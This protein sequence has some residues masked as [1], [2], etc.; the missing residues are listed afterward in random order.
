MAFERGELIFIFNFHSTKSVADYP[1]LV[2]P[3]TPY[4]IALDT[5]EAQFGGQNRIDRKQIFNLLP[6]MRGNERVNIINI[7]IPCRTAMV[8]KRVDA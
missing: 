6:E 8:L 2:P 1:I 5:D 4:T 3:G 7:Y